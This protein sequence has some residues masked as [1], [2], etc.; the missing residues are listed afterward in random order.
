[1]T[2]SVKKM[3]CVMLLV[4]GMTGCTGETVGYRQITQEEAADLMSS[5]S[6]Y[7][8]VDV[9]RQDEYDAGH[10]PDA[11]LIP[12][13]SITDERPAELPD[14]SQMILIYCRSGNRSKL[15]A[16]KL[17]AMGYTNIY[18]FGGINTWTGE[19]VTEGSDND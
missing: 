5:N 13:E 7:I 14:T 18:E 4:V 11:V 15:A 17:S 9:R 3:L 16:E 8:I 10:I 12:N 6:G 19:T 2:D 1:M